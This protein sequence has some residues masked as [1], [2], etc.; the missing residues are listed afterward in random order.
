MQRCKDQAA[1]STQVKEPG[2]KVLALKVLER[3]HRDIPVRLN[4]LK[5]PLLSSHG[6]LTLS[7]NRMHTLVK[8]FFWQGSVT[9]LR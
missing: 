3:Q 6:L 7:T 8:G 5:R 4:I 1:Q 2:T 9:V